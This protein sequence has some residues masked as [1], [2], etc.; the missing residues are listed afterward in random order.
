MLLPYLVIDNK[1]CNDIVPTHHHHLEPV[2]DIERERA[3]IETVGPIRQIKGN[4]LLVWSDSRIR[5]DLK[6]KC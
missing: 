3:V 4:E 1:T 5:P 2:Q 6:D